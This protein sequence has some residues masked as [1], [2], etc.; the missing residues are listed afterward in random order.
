MIVINFHFI[1]ENP[2]IISYQ[3]SFVYLQALGCIF[4][5]RFLFLCFLHW[6]TF[7]CKIFTVCWVSESCSSFHFTAYSRYWDLL[8][9]KGRIFRNTNLYFMQNLISYISRKST[10]S[11]YAPFTLL[12]TL[13]EGA[14]C[15][16]RSWLKHCATS[17]K[18]ADP[19]PDGVIGIFHWHNSSDRTIALGVDSASN[20]TEYQKYFLRV[21]A[22]GAYGWQRYHF[23]CRLSWNLE[24]S[25]SWNP[26]VL[27]RPVMGL[28]YL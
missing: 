1:S 6:H 9:V 14:R 26:Q 11:N 4:H 27:S 15:W 19:I 3:I 17:R 24:A 5:R 20:R 10:V 21:K 25:T 8:Q 18:V 12:I 13:K 2:G 7:L 23:K 16:W 28:L 22:A